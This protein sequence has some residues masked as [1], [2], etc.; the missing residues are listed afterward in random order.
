MVGLEEREYKYIIHSSYF[1]SCF[2]PPCIGLKINGQPNCVKKKKAPKSVF[3][4]CGFLSVLCIER[5]LA[6][7]QHASLDKVWFLQ[8]R[9]I[10]TVPQLLLNH[11]EQPRVQRWIGLVQEFSL[12]LSVLKCQSVFQPYQ[13]SV[14]VSR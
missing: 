2:L 3:L 5:L 8:C 11:V 1:F 12:K 7:W 6:V 10:K 4:L 14:V 9:E 13:A